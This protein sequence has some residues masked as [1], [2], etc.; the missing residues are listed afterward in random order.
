MPKFSA[1]I[2]AGGSASRMNGINKQLA[3]LDGIPVVIRSALAFERSSEVSEIILAVPSGE[4][5]RYAAL[6]SQYG[7]TKLKTAVH[8][9]ATRFLSV[10]NALAQVSTDCT[11]I[12]IHDGARP[13][14]S[15]EDV[16]RVLR[17]AAE[18]NAAIAAAPVTDTIKQTSNGVISSTP[19]RSALYAAQTPQAFLKSL[20]LSCVE[21]LGSRAEELT[22]DSALLEL[23]G[24]QVHITP[25]TACNMKVTRP[26]D[27]AIAE[28]VLKR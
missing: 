6:C 17:D 12:A 15:T 13:L 26:Q 10:K 22:D 3:L 24:E 28:A 23:C 20:Y 21:R 25:V 14:I 18:Y 9:G 27:L 4:E 8:G 11:H 19:D 5:E 2:L 1:V 7:V 16:D